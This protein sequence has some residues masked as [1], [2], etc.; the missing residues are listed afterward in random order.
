MKIREFLESEQKVINEKVKSDILQQLGALKQVGMDD[1]EQYK[2]LEKQY[3]QY[4]NGGSIADMIGKEFTE[5]FENLINNLE[6][7]EDVN[8]DNLPDELR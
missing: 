1:T 7:D 5:V 6:E 2:E 8:G 3:E 4:E